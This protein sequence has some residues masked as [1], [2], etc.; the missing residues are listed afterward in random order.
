MDEI[1]FLE[2]FVRIPSPSYQEAEVAG[3]LVRSMEQLG[4]E[5]QRDDAGNAV[6]IIGK[7]GPLVVLLGHIDTVPGD[8]PV[9]IEDGKLYGRG[10]VDAKGPFATFV[11]A[12]ARAAHHQTLA[13]RV[14]VIG[15]VEEEVASSKGANYVADKYQPAYCII[16]EP[17]QWDRITLGYRG[18][19]LLHYHHRQAG[20]HS[21][22]DVQAVP[23]HAVAFWNAIA[24]YCQT[25]NAGQ[26]RL[27]EQLSPALRHIASRSD[28]LYDEVEA[29]IS[30]RLPEG[31]DPQ[32]L[33]TTLLSCADSNS[34]VEIAE[35]CPAY[36]SA[37]S[38]RLANTFVRGI[39]DT[40]GT[41]GFIHKTG[42]SDMNVVGPVWN[43]PII[44]YGPGDSR[45]DHTPNEHIILADYHRAIDVLTYVLSRLDR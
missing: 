8:I 22:G 17:S 9:H 28:G 23:E 11:C 15:A 5:A 19:L 20:A 12:A 24:D 32:A 14:V 27:F 16:G 42:T 2:Q 29:T 40:G 21:A 41:P 31:V 43:I 26:K 18:R 7:S 37:R 30:L 10:S 13:C 44:A 3:Y 25:Y 1:A 4:F 34:A 38:T 33:A 36:R 39:R 6:G 35:T 45:M